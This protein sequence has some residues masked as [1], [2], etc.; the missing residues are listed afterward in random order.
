MTDLEAVDNYIVQ[1]KRFVNPM[2]LGDITRRGLYH[3]INFLPRNVDEAKAVARARMAKMGKYF[4]DEEIDKIAGEVS[5]LEFL[6]NELNKL[7]MADAHAVIPII[8]EMQKISEFVRD[9]FKPVNI[10]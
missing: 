7:N 8:N 1:C 5:R 3:V 10:Q 9:Y 4:G 2:L 6:R